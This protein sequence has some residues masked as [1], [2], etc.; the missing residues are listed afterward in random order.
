VCATRLKHACGEC[1]TA[2]DPLWQVCPYCGAG[3]VAPVTEL[4]LTERT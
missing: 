2:L 3:A 4:R 1:D